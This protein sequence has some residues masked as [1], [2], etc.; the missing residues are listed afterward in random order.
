VTALLALGALLRVLFLG[1]RSLWFD[2]AS[3]LIL[4]RLTLVGLPGLLVR[5]EM[6][7]PLYYALMHFWL[8]FFSDPRLGLRLF[9][10]LSGI[11]ALAAFIPLARRLLPGR[12]LLLAGFFAACSS[13]WLH[14][15]QDGRVYSCLLLVSVLC[16]RAVWDLGESRSPRRWAAYAALSAL[17]L[18]LHYYFA[19]PLAAHAAWLGWRFRRSPRDL[20][21][22]AAAHAAVA[23]LFAP[24]VPHLLGQLRAHVGDLTVGDALT[25]AHLFDSLGNM[26]FDVTFLGLALP[27][28]L[29]AAI[30]ACFAALTGAFAAREWRSRLDPDERTRLAFVLVELAL[31]IALIGVAE[32]LVG[33]PITQARYFI[34]LSP[35]VFLLAARTLSSPGR[36]TSV[37][38]LAF[39][40]VVVAG[41]IGYFASGRLVDP[42]LDGLAASIRR[43]DP[44]LPVVYV[45]NYYYL[46]MRY[47]YL[48]ERGNFLVAEAAESMDY[49]GMPPYDGVLDA[50]RRRRLGPCVVVDAKRLLSPKTLW[51]GTGAQLDGLMA[52]ALVNEM[53][54]PPRRW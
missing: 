16:I 53:A 39:E 54:P 10:A 2:E 19:F 48:T 36:A 26:F 46:P 32:L 49:A 45:T 17:G 51:L 37:L 14:A 21:A 5:N 13:Y 11:A 20:R 29:N 40:A 44:R 34:P 18:H 35:F 23:L 9:S 28:W 33:R 12:A 24:W 43:A 31:P 15:A 38:R 7:P 6:N 30:G 27:H 1:T 52:R 3:T 22:W 41:A 42:R 25:P 8:K 50:G 4:A 47:Y